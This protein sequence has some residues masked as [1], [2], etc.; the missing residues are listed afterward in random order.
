MPEEPDFFRHRTPAYANG[1]YGKGRKYS[2][3]NTSLLVKG[4]GPPYPH[5]SSV[6]ESI[7]ATPV[8]TCPSCCKLPILAELCFITGDTCFPCYSAS[9]VKPS[10]SLAETIGSLKATPIPANTTHSASKMD[11]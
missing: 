1:W 4:D 3:L 11:W 10:G 7:K 2:D 9:Q 8:I 6:P 5:V